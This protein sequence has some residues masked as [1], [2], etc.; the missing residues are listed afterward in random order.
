[1]V[2]RGSEGQGQPAKD[3]G[4]DDDIGEGGDPQGGDNDLQEEVVEAECVQGSRHGRDADDVL[5]I[6]KR[7]AEGTFIWQDQNIQDVYLRYLDEGMLTVQVRVT[8]D[9]HYAQ[10]GPRVPLGTFLWIWVPFRFPFLSQGP[11]ISNLG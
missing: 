11:L 7:D 2:A 5:W 1:M 9:L 8:V 3:Q 6:G 4:G 10:L